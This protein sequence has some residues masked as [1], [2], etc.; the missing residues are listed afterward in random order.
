MISRRVDAD[1]E[2]W[3]ATSFADRIGG[4]FPFLFFRRQRNVLRRWSGAEKAVKLGKNNE[5]V[6]RG[7]FEFSDW[8]FLHHTPGVK[9][10]TSIPTT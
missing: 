1:Q 8:G 3:S 10:T 4:F 2:G 5:F 9:L 7:R 6:M